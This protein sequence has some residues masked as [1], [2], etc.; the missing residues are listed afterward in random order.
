MADGLDLLPR[1][2]A[3][4]R[5]LLAQHLPEVEVWVYGSRA[6]GR[7]HGGSDLDLVLRA[8][9]LV[10]IPARRL[11]RLR[12]ALQDS[13]IPFLV[14]THDWARMPAEFRG[15]IEAAHIVLVGGTVTGDGTES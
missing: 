4:I 2:R 9:G 5:A 10:P 3:A 13:R 15:R 7:S 6:D 14:E 1:H 11:A 12:G 8:P